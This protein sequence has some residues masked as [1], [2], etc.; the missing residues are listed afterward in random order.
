MRLRALL[1]GG[2]A[3]SDPNDCARCGRPHPRCKGHNQQG[4]PCMRWPRRGVAVCPRH[5]GHAPQVIAAAERRLREE[6]AERAV[7]TFGLPREVDPAQALLEEV[8]RTAGHVAWVG[9]VVA[10]LERDELVWGLAEEIDRPVTDSGGGV[11]TKH[12]AGVSV[13]V[14]LYQRERRH[15]AQ[16]SKAAIDAGVSERMVSVFEQVGAAYVSVLERV[17][18]ELELSPAQRQ[19]VPELVRG[20]LVALTGGEGS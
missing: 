6:E 12:K 18:D 5:G 14:E 19:R 4:E 20:H 13:W 10:G 2:H 1:E 17:L 16:V 3:M 9:A 15:L 11:E 7:V 8:H